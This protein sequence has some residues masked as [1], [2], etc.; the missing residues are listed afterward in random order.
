MAFGPIVYFVAPNW[1]PD[2]IRSAEP[3]G[4]PVP[5]DPFRSWLRN[6]GFVQQP[7]PGT[8]FT[9]DLIDSCIHQI[10]EEVAF[11]RFEFSVVKDAPTLIG[12]WQTLVEELCEKWGFSLIDQEKG[13]KV[14]VDQFRRILVQDR[15]W[16]I[17]GD[18]YGWS[19]IWPEQV[20]PPSAN[21]GNQEQMLHESRH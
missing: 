14:P 3:K 17:A 5:V 15:I 7:G 21:V 6:I 20:D 16:R 13:E 8:H 2:V 11:T 19:P 10:D 18:V 9:W 4:D 12:G 1:E